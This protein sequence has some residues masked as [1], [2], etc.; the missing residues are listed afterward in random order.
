M[1][2]QIRGA[3]W[4][5]T[6]ASQRKRKQIVFELTLIL[7]YC[8]VMGVFRRVQQLFSLDAFAKRLDEFVSTIVSDQNKWNIKSLNWH[9]CAFRALIAIFHFCF[10]FCSTPS[11]CHHRNRSTYATPP[12]TL[13]PNNAQLRN[14]TN[15]T[16]YSKSRRCANLRSEVRVGPLVADADKSRIARLE[17]S[18][19]HQEAQ[20]WFDTSF[21]KIKILTLVSP[22]RE[23]ELLVWR[24]WQRLLFANMRHDNSRCNT[25]LL[26]VSLITN[27]IQIISKRNEP[28]VESDR[29]STSMRQPSGVVTSFDSMHVCALSQSDSGNT[30]PCCMH[31]NTPTVELF[32]PFNVPNIN[33]QTH[34]FYT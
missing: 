22:V 32:A 1:L 28:G 11:Q 20:P 8:F 19:S 33:S 27:S 26:F 10:I 30:T 24:M 25:Y 3:K 2:V 18:P 17:H 12:T 5:R 16:Q 7:N 6:D 15:T 9:I 21:I 34:K 14:E 29:M 31:R 23:Y 13:S 4:A